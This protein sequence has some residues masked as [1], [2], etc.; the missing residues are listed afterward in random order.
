M[1]QTRINVI[2]K[3]EDHCGQT[4]CRPDHWAATLSDL[5]NTERLPAFDGPL[6]RL[7]TGPA[8]GPPR[9][10]MTPKLNLMSSQGQCPG[11]PLLCRH[12]WTC[13]YT[14]WGPR[15]FLGYCPDDRGQEGSG[16]LWPILGW[17][18]CWHGDWPVTVAGSSQSSPDVQL[19]F[20]GP[21]LEP[22]GRN[23][24]RDDPVLLE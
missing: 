22:V 10:S 5:N 1:K 21:L 17:V 20:Q 14:M 24:T 15:N 7:Q 16:P 19:L 8:T 4:L 13:P 9:I 18:S 12:V 2:W 3:A 23:Y 11:W 6:S